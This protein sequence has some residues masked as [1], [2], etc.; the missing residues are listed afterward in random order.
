MAKKKKV[1][2]FLDSDDKWRREQI[3]LFQTI[4]ENVNG[5]EWMSPA[6]KKDINNIIN[7]AQNRFKIKE[8]FN[9]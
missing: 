4:K 7:K 8:L 2:E 5:Y 1:E 6:E 3:N 9:E